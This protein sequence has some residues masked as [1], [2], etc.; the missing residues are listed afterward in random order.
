[1]NIFGYE[2]EEKKRETGKNLKKACH[3]NRS[4]RDLAMIFK[5]KS[6]SDL[7]IELS[8]M[9]LLIEVRYQINNQ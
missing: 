4:R 2:W 6:N 7:A 3:S 9:L 5:N 1:M 8:L